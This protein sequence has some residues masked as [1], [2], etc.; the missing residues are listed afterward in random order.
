MVTTQPLRE[1][2]VTCPTGAKGN[3]RIAHVHWKMVL[4]RA[5]LLQAEQCINARI[6]FA[7][8]MQ[9]AGIVLYAVTSHAKTGQHDE[10]VTS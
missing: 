6:N 1:S 9:A 7:R 5:T 2:R 10:R 4:D 3:S 8:T